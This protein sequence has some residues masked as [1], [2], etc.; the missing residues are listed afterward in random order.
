MRIASTRRIQEIVRNE[1]ESLGAM[2]AIFG[3]IGVCNECG[4]KTK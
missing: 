2:F 1:T 4:V 3:S